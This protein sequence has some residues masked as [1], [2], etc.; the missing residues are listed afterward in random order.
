M[1]AGEADADGAVVGDENFGNILLDV[2]V[3]RSLNVR[4]VLVHGASA[5]I[6]ALIGTWAVSWLFRVVG[7]AWLILAVL[8]F[9]IPSSPR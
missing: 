6:Q 1:A 4:T 5:Q 8:H 7:A 2:A 3:L 9:A